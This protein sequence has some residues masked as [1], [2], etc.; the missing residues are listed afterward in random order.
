MCSAGHRTRQI[1]H[2]EGCV[3]ENK[4]AYFGIHINNYHSLM[5]ALYTVKGVVIYFKLW[6]RHNKKDSTKHLKFQVE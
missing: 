3:N 5:T 2:Y 1:K 4:T 6:Q